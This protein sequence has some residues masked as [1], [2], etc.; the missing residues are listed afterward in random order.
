MRDILKVKVLCYR[1][2]KGKWINIAGIYVFSQT[3]SYAREETIKFISNVFISYYLFPI[4]V[5]FMLDLAER[6]RVYW[7]PLFYYISMDIDSNETANINPI[8]FSSGRFK[9]HSDFKLFQRFV[10]EKDAST[11]G[12]LCVC[13][14]SQLKHIMVKWGRLM[15]QVDVNIL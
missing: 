8:S 5:K 2:Y 14:S 10:A 11:K 4:Y 3:W 15:F 1:C 7:A 13:V 9:W 12:V 6:R